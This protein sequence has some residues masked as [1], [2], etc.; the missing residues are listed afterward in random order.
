[1]MSASD[2]NNAVGDRA[3]KRKL[4]S[5]TQARALLPVVREMTAEAVRQADELADELD[6][7]LDDDDP[8]R[9]VLGAEL[10]V[11]VDGWAARIREMGLEAN[12]LWLVDFDNG[13]GYY[14]WQHP[15]SSVSHYHGYEEGFAGRMKI[16]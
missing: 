12:G 5:L 15:E 2:Y 8:Q 4:F 3:E 10:K 7:I 13:E 1:M 16:V 6:H 14:C 9:S 11:V